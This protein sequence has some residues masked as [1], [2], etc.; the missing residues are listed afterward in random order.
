MDTFKPEAEIKLDTS[1]HRPTYNASFKP[2]AVISR[3]HIMVGVG[4]LVL[5]LLI[6]GIN[7]AL[8]DSRTDQESQKQTSNTTNNNVNTTAGKGK[9]SELSRSSTVNHQAGESHMLTATNESSTVN[10]ADND[11]QKIISPIS[12]IPTQAELIP[13]PSGQQRVTLSGDLNDA[14]T[15]QQHQINAALMGRGS[16]LS[17]APTPSNVVND[18]QNSHVIH[19][20]AQSNNN[21]LQHQPIS[22]K[23]KIQDTPKP[24]IKISQRQKA[25]GI[26][27]LNGNYTLQLS[28]AS[29]ADTLNAWAKKQNLAD[30]Y[31]YKSLHKDHPWYV[32]ISGS[33][34]TQ[35]EAKRAVTSLPTEV[36][37]QNPWVKP[38]TL[39][40]RES[41]H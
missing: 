3:Q 12:S 23:P 36:R 8:N 10:L 35:T 34:V 39:V 7:S 26:A 16:T 40:R 5:L 22:I 24:E 6:I 11:R 13:P 20:P 37:A 28:S 1:D 15:A 14:L 4:I 27:I 21:A 31:I 19:A 9:N 30:Y 32:L 29:R 25:K 33:Y 38:V 18:Q 2:K 17:T 41:G